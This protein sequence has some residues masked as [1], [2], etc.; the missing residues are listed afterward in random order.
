M[1]I[2]VRSATP[3]DAE[4]L[5]EV[6]YASWQRG[7][8]PLVDAAAAA[9][10]SEAT[11]A[12]FIRANAASILVA[13][14]AGQTLGFA[15]IEEDDLSDLW[16]GPAYEGQGAGSA[17]LE[18]AATAVAARG[19][20]AITLEVMTENRRAPALYQRHGFQV[21]WQGRRFDDIL[22]CELDKTGME[23]PL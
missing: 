6:G 12:D 5:A 13:E 10:V 23:K 15:A 18:A 19:H 22:R 16:V 7:I 3:E 20:R 11:Y 14:R 4:T 2:T 21:V 9:K 1:A 8:G 17:L